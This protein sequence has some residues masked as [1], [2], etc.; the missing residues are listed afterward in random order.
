[1]D[2][3][4]IDTFYKLLH[5]CR[6]TRDTVCL[7]FTDG[8]NGFQRCQQEEHVDDDN[9]RSFSKVTTKMQLRV[10]AGATDT[11]PGLH[12]CTS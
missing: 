11:G 4:G 9:E 6:N 2:T 3:I 8:G 12:M 10:I 1:M 5:I 7:P